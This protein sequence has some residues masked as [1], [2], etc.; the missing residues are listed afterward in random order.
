MT[1]FVLDWEDRNSGHNIV[2]VYSTLA[3]ARDAVAEAKLVYNT[4]WPGDGWVDVPAP[5]G[6]P[7]LVEGVRANHD[8]GP[9]G[10]ISK[11]EVIQ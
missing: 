4:R 10:W 5:A 3:L 1:V 11:Y 2:G 8:D 6:W 9:K 7:H